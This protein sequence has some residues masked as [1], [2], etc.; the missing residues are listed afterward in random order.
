MRVVAWLYVRVSAC[1]ASVYAPCV[2]CYGFKKRH[3][4]TQRKTNSFSK[5]RNLPA[6]EY[7]TIV[8]RYFEVAAAATRHIDAKLI[9][10]MD[11]SPVWYDTVHGQTL[12]FK[13]TEC[14]HYRVQGELFT[15]A[16][17]RERHPKSADTLQQ[18]PLAHLTH[19]DTHTH[20]PTHTSTHEQTHTLSHTR[21]HTCTYT[22]TSDASKQ[23]CTMCAHTF[24]NPRR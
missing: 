23:L 2:Q 4:L 1:V 9:Y 21:S 6:A 8:Y 10:N 20:T 12:E 19:A 15:W 14:S 13:G 17:N 18:V 22:P 3:R 24:K 7:R 16:A 11:E 5:M